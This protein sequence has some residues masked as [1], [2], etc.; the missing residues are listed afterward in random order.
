[1]QL[2]QITTDNYKGS[3]RTSRNKRRI[4]LR[5]LSRDRGEPEQVNVEFTNRSEMSGIR[6]L[7]R[8]L[9]TSETSFHTTLDGQTVK[10]RTTPVRGAFVST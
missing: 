2:G 4:S 6:E 7:L 3:M 8:R 1:M 5:L 9:P 10:V